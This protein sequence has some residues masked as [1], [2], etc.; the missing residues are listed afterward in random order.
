[1]RQVIIVGV[2]AL[3]CASAHAAEGPVGMVE[4]PCP[5]PLDPPAALREQIT[6]LFI[7]P[8]V[9]TPAQFA[10]FVKNDAARWRE[11]VREAGIQPE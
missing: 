1:M 7:E 8:R 10:A 4:Q 2:L 5:P 9:I 3:L 6:S 11:Y